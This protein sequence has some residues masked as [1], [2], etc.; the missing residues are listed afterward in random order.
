M[1]PQAIQLFEL[2]CRHCGLAGGRGV[3]IALGEAIYSRK[4]EE[5][6]DEPEVWGDG[7]RVADIVTLRADELVLGIGVSECLKV[8]AEE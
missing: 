8:D 6:R 4:V 7:S 5:T 1:I 3:E 2:G